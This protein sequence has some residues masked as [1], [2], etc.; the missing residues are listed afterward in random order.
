MKKIKKK[1]K[2]KHLERRFKEAA[3]RLFGDRKRLDKYRGGDGV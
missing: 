3:V 1:E 2:E